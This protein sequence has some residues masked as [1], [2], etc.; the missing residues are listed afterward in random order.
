MAGLFTG[1]PNDITFTTSQVEFV[2]YGPEG[3]WPYKRP[4]QLWETLDGGITWS[5]A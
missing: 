1:G 5:P 4:G 2:V 3:V